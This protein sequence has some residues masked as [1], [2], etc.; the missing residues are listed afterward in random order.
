MTPRAPRVRGRAC[1]FAE[2][3]RD[4]PPYDRLR[5][6]TRLSARLNCMTHKNWLFGRLNDH[7]PRSNRMITSPGQRMIT[8][9]GQISKCLSHVPPGEGE[10]LRLIGRLPVREA[11]LARPRG[12]RRPPRHRRVRSECAAGRP[13]SGSPQTGEY[14][15]Q[16]GNSAHKALRDENP[17]GLPGANLRSARACSSAGERPLHTREVTGS[18]PVTPIA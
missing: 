1:L 14:G 5:D 6:R 3:S 2:G 13:R 16:H 10:R 17:R 18:I 15:K 9:P 8:S 12:A 4:L 7:K 11:G